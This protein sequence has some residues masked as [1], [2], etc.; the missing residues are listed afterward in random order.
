MKK[1]KIGI[2]FGGKSA[3]HEV[4]LQS[5]KSIYEAI[6]RSRYKPI[7]IAITKNG[8]WKMFQGEDFFIN[9][10]NPE[11]IRLN[12]SDD[13]IAIIPQ[14]EGDIINFNKPD[15]KSKIDCIF[16]ILHGTYGE[17]GTVQG[18]IKLIDVPFVGA[19]VLGSAVG[20]DKD[21]MKRLLNEANIKNAK[22][23]IARADSVPNFGEVEKTLGLP[24]FIKPAN[25]G[26]SV[27]ISKVTDIAEYDNAIKEAFLYDTKI[28]IE[29]FVDGRE[30]ECSVLGNTEVRSSVPGEIVVKSDFYSYE[31]KYIDNTAF[32]LEI[33]A[34]V[35]EK[36][37]SKI[38]KLACKTFETLCC[39]GMG[40]VDMFLRKDN[41][42]YVNEIN[43]IP[44]FT[45]NSMYPKLW[46]ASGLS[47]KDLITKLIEL[48]IERFN[49]EKSLKTTFK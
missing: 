35:S 38:M 26:S 48:S 47:Y 5:A 15:L 43:T 45:K 3:E 13:Y 4:S 27:G 14:S 10:D 29:E 1:Q 12:E 24:I 11:K 22:C 30:I 33:P 21:V 37:Q 19:G 36:L 20:M 39:E 42:I 8:G 17:D 7:M 34:N 28:L 16:P 23:M 32:E 9:P 6:D 49:K 2:L 18:M 31:A 46:E 40:R 44:G 25:L 41:S